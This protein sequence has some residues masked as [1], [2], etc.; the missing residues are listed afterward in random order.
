MREIADIA[1]DDGAAGMKCQSDERRIGWIWQG[2]TSDWI[3]LEQDLEILESF[4]EFG[5]ECRRESKMRSAQH[6]CVL[7]QDI[8][9][10]DRQP[11]PSSAAS[12]TRAGG[13]SGFNAAET[14]TLVSTTAR[15]AFHA[16]FLGSSD[17]RVD[18]IHGHF[19]QT[20]FARNAPH[21]LESR[22]KSSG[23]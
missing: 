18:L 20:L 10:D 21:L 5:N 3:W 23:P 12:I 9:A 8:A 6:G 1:G 4:D 15:I 2:I 7:G 11:L 16:L 22:L 17:F 19:V 14:S 13:P